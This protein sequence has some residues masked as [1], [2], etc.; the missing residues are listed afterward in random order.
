MFFVL[1]LVA[2][3]HPR[4]RA[5]TGHNS[6][7]VNQT[8]TKP[9]RNETYEL[10]DPHQMNSCRCCYDSLFC[11]GS[12]IIRGSRRRRSGSTAS[13]NRDLDVVESSSIFCR[14]TSAKKTTTSLLRLGPARSAERSD[15]RFQNLRAPG[16]RG[17]KLKR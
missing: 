15:A 12:R 9:T 2:S 1:V 7:R 10:P 4:L 3:K 13:S 11:C 6:A 17:S 5:C 8:R 16:L 14:C